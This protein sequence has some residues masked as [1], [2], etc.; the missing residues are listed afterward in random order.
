MWFV[1]CALV[2]A[3]LAVGGVSAQGANSQPAFPSGESGARSVAE[4]TTAG[5]SIGAPISATDAENDALTYTLGGDDAASFAIVSSTGQL[6][7]LA[8]LNFEEKDT[9]N[10]RVSASDQKDAAG[11]AD[12]VTDDDID[13]T[14]SVTNV[15]EPGTIILSSTL[16]RVGEVIRGR[17]SDPDGG[18]STETWLWQKSEDGAADSWTL[19]DPSASGFPS[20]TE[21]PATLLNHHLRVDVGYADEQG[22]GKIARRVIGLVAGK[23]HAPQLHVEGAGHRPEHSLGNRL[24]AR[25]DDAVHRTRGQAER[26]THQRI[27][28]DSRR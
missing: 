14:I 6:Q 2:F 24:Y 13:V 11:N 10:V 17:V 9:Y 7:T 28:A 19:I 8:D 26:P 5:E 25:R 27:D 20:Y 16:A 1:V 23:A 22:S 4:N 18:V 15:N 21:V 12:T 3:F